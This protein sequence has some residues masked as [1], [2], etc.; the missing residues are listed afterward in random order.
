MTMI[1]IVKAVIIGISCGVIWLIGKS[2]EKKK[3]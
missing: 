3:G 1:M 2:S